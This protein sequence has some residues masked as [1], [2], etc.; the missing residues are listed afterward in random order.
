MSWN[1]E[2]QQIVKDCEHTGNCPCRPEE[3][4]VCKGTGI[5]LFVKERPL[6]R[7]YGKQGLI[8]GLITASE[9]EVRRLG[10]RR[11]GYLIGSEEGEEMTCPECHGEGSLS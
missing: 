4:E 3:C 6:V 5:V 11:E 9:A 1:T 10:L 7:C 8:S 2:A